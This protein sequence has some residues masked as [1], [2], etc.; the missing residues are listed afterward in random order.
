VGIA[1]EDMTAAAKA[2]GSEKA[3]F[4][5]DTGGGSEIVVK[6]GEGD[7]TGS[8]ESA[9]QVYATGSSSR[10]HVKAEDEDTGSSSWLQ[11]V[12]MEDQ[13]STRNVVV[14]TEVSASPRNGVLNGR[15]EAAGKGEEEDGA[16]QRLARRSHGLKATMP[17]GEHHQVCVCSGLHSC[18]YIYADD[19]RFR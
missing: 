2:Q 11:L 1:K 13:G 16:D 17:R 9:M 14:E 8:S 7:D 6:Q 3:K 4:P 10:V 12:A 15:G 18:A 5:E 19:G